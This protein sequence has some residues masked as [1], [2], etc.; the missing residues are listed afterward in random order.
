M[1]VH[2]YMQL[3]TRKNIWQNEQDSHE[4]Q[5]LVNHTTAL[6]W[7]YENRSFHTARGILSN[8]TTALMVLRIL[9]HVS[10]KFTR[11]GR[12]DIFHR[13]TRH[14]LQAQFPRGDISLSCKRLQVFR[15]TS[16]FFSPLGDLASGALVGFAMQCGKYLE[17]REFAGELLVG[18]LSSREFIH[19]GLNP[20]RQI[21][22]VAL[23]F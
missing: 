23:A 10:S 15:R 21:G 22:A 18:T 13:S 6:N 7:G 16:Y 11:R 1:N 5:L 9:S 12:N 3:N 20:V 17:T 4:K 19:I 8:V 2:K 14:G